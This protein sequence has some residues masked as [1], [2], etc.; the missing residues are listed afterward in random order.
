MTGS[1][2]IWHK[3]PL[4]ND[5]KMDVSVSRWIMASSPMLQKK[6]NPEKKRDL[7]NSPSEQGFPLW[8]V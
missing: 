1:P 7:I 3:Q 5:T 6:V 2:V 8:R 4:G